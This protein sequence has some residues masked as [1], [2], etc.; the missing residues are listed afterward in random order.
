[1]G[2]GVGATNQWQ[3]PI[4]KSAAA[5]VTRAFPV[6]LDGQWGWSPIPGRAD[7]VYQRFGDQIGI[8]TDLAHRGLMIAQ[9]LGVGIASR[10][11]PEVEITSP[12]DGYVVGGG[13]G[14]DAWAEGAWDT[15]AWDTG[16]WG[17]GVLAGGP[18]AWAEGVWGEGAGAWAEGAWGDTGPLPPGLFVAMATD[19]ADGNL[20]SVIE[21][22]SNK[23]GPL[24][25]GPSITPTFASSG[26]HIVYAGVKNTDGGGN[27]ARIRVYVP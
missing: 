8:D 9:N 15:G 26:M 25:V 5:Q 21:W 7:G 22:W 14:G 16:A 10:A 2:R 17:E 19:A 24:G 6:E 11:A 1:M 4:A 23:D 27:L 20:S 13:G 18:P 12:G 3:E